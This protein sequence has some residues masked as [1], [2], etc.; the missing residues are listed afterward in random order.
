MKQAIVRIAAAVLPLALLAGTASARAGETVAAPGLADALRAT[1]WQV[2]RLPD[3]GLE[4][5]LSRTPAPPE[6][7][8]EATPPA[9][10]Q[11]E[12]AAWDRLR[13]KGW[14]VERAEDGSILLFPP[15]ASAAPAGAPATTPSPQPAAQRPQPE[16]PEQ[17][18]TPEASP[19]AGSM[20]SLLR[21]R[22]WRAERQA[23]GTLLAYPM[24]RA[25]RQP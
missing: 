21:A 8:A 23:D 10:P 15:I 19:P 9:Q 18:A 2:H 7:A 22:G 1:G 4:A 6:P 20:E 14:R 13:A 5:R 16:Q 17:P 25:P 11:A 24:G 3:G 12:V